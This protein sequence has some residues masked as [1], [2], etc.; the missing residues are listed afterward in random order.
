MAQQESANIVADASAN[1]KQVLE[2]GIPVSQSVI[3][4]LQRDFYSQRGLR[5][6]TQDS[7]PSY[8]TNN[9]FIAEIYAGIIVAFVQDCMAQT[10]R[11]LSRE[12]PLRILELGAGAGKF[13][14]LLLRKLTVLLRANGISPA[15]VR[16]AMTDCSE[17]LVSEWRGN[18]W[19]AEFVDS[20]LLEFGV[21]QAG[22]KKHEGYLEQFSM[23]PRGPL[24]V[25]ANYV[26]D[27]LPQ[28]AFAIEDG[29]VHEMLQTTSAEGDPAILENLRFSYEKRKISSEHYSNALWNSILEHYRTRISRATV[30]FP[31]TTLETLQ[32]LGALSDG[33]MLVLAADKGFAHEMDLAL[34]QGEPAL[35]FHASKRCFSQLVNF[36]A[37]A[38]YFQSSGGEALVPGKHF[39]GLSLCAFLHCHTGDDFTGARKAYQ[40]AV[41]GFGPDDL[42]AVMSWLN[43]HLGE[44]SLAQALALLRLTRWDP[45][46][47]VQLFPAMARQVRNAGAERNDL[48]EAV[49]K[50]WEN[51]YPVAHDENVVAFYCGVI[52]LELR[53][54]AEAYDMLRRSQQL[55]GP[56]AATSYNL[57]LCCLGLNQSGQALEFMREACGLDSNFEPA[58]Q[59]RSRL[60][61]QLRADES[62]QS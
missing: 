44:V 6:W 11:H 52:L 56:S 37:I 58:R 36:D 46:A 49:L 45:A 15:I 55:F 41:D 27:S 5:A 25:I 18:P 47:L 33:R 32:E 10:P 60:E 9:P 22:R 53:F 59:S 2:Q 1:R 3:W 19:L 29:H 39:T 40:Q 38:K 54:F 21:F 16:Y 61:A 17:T 28:D 43:A 24:V 31:T 26:F 51:H 42:F 34:I 50:T 62:K 35:E 57:G 23:R 48:R 14:C 12:A 13:S 4:Q 7:V 8:I 20:G 30:L